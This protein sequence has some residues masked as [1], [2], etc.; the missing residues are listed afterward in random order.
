MSSRKRVSDHVMGVTW[1]S[2]ERVWSGKPFLKKS[3]LKSGEQE[4]DSHM[5]VC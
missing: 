4:G 3:H 2:P 5:G 1:E